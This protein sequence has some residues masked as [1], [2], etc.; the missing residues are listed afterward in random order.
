M[1]LAEILGKVNSIT[2]LVSL[3]TCLQIGH[4]TLD[5]T[6]NNLSFMIHFAILLRGRCI[7]GFD[8]KKNYIRCFAHIV[9]LCSQAVIRS[10]EKDDMDGDYPDTDTEPG[11]DSD[12]SDDA[13]VVTIRP[14][15]TSRKAGP[16][17]RARKSI[18]F[19]RKSGQRRDEFLE[20]IRLGNEDHTWTQVVVVNGQA[21]KV[22]VNLA[23]VTVLPDVKT[24]WDSVFFMLRRLRYLQ[25]VSQ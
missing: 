10:M 14:T 12:V 19:I 24:R 25:Q 7:V 4:F 8:A 5:N 18:R 3:L 13:A 6:S 17:Q 16:I 23:L 22:T 1:E 20:I 15:R 11:T 9:N 2:E 21:E